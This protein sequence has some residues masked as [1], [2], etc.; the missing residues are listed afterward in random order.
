MFTF[1]VDQTVYA[2]GTSAICGFDV[3]VTTQGTA[4]VMLFVSQDGS[5]VVR[6]MDWNTGWTQTFSAPALGTSYTQ[7]TAGPLITTYPEG[8]DLGD[9]ATAVVV[10]S[11]GRIGDDPGEAG[12]TVFDA[13]VVFVDPAT[14]IP[15]IDFV[16]VQSS[17]GHFLG[18]NAV[19]RCEALAS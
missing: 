6:E 5:S 12:R 1:E 10:G 11:N 16:G 13:V 8:T 3:F 7:R 19:R 4:H 2:P 14:G 15:G 17:V 18:G 9:P